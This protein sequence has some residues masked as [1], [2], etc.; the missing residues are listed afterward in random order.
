V[1]IARARPM[2][3]QFPAGGE[4]VELPGKL[5]VHEE[6]PVE[7]ADHAGA[8]LARAAAAPAAAPARNVI[9]AV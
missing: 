9:R 4:L 3:D 2:L 6:R 1:S 7:W 5:F 8:F